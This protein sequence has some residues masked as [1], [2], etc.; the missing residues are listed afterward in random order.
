MRRGYM[1]Q[2]GCQR[3]S[4]RTPDRKGWRIHVDENDNGS[5]AGFDTQFT[6]RNTMTMTVNCMHLATMLK[7][8][9]GIPNRGNDRKA[10]RAG[11]SFGFEIPY[12]KIGS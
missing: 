10:L 1:R 9:G 6:Q 8:G 11:E 2:A 5:R 12:R 3:A 7:A 4:A